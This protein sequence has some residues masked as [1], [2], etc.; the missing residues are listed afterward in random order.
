MSKD[1]STYCPVCDTKKFHIL[2]SLTYGIWHDA[3]AQNIEREVYTFDLGEC[4]NCGH[5]KVVSEYTDQIFHKIYGLSSEGNI[6]WGKGVEGVKEPYAEMIRFVELDREKQN[7]IIDLGCGNGTLLG[8]L[9]NQFGCDNEQLLGLDFHNYMEHNFA[10]ANLS[11]NDAN[12]IASC[13]S[14]ES[15]D[16]VFSSHVLEHLLNPAATMAAVCK[17]MKPMAKIYIEVPD[18]AHLLDCNSGNVPLVNQQHIQYFTYPNLIHM[19]ERCG[20]ELIKTQ[21]KITGELP[22]LMMLA[23]KP[24]SKLKPFLENAV[25]VK[26]QAAQSLAVMRERRARLGTM[27]LEQIN[28]GKPVGS[29]QVGPQQVGPQQVG[30]WGIGADFHKTLDENQELSQQLGSELITLFDQGLAGKV[31]KGK[32]IHSSTDIKDFAGTVFITPMLRYVREGMMQAA[33]DNGFDNSKI[34]DPYV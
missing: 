32:K 23:Q 19:M 1:I 8:I 30:F 12:D 3:N 28:D 20:F 21:R 14:L 17:K 9:K 15:A 10:F 18:N 26:N 5:I 25:S 4:D 13:S 2:D 6:Y 11:L 29:Q 22:R 16:I 27:V 24:K 34:V 7:K 33:S 31:F